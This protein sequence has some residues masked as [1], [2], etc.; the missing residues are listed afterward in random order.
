M[1]FSNIYLLDLFKN[2]AKMFF[3]IIFKKK[4]VLIKNNVLNKKNNTDKQK[5]SV[6]FDLFKK[7]LSSL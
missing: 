7:T 3:F 6:C 5:K 1:K 2:C 4:H